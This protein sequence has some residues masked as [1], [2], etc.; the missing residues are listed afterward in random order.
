MVGGSSR[1][2]VLQAKLARKQTENLRREQ[3]LKVRGSRLSLSLLSHAKSSLGDAK[4]SLGDVKS[5][6][7]DVQV[8][9]PFS[10]PE[11]HNLATERAERERLAQDGLDNGSPT[12]SDDDSDDEAAAEA[13]K[14]EADKAEELYGEVAQVVGLVVITYNVWC[15]GPLGCETPEIF[16]EVMKTRMQAIGDIVAAQK[17]HLVCFQEMTFFIMALLQTQPWSKG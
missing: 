5:S 4:S 17:P 11:V 6:L 1:N 13:D 15:N 8:V 14:A 12:H 9:S 2:A 10:L 16:A 3:E 7:G